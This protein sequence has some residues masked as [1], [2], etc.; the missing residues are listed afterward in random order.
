MNEERYHEILPAAYL[1]AALAKGGKPSALAVGLS[2]RDIEAAENPKNPAYRI[3]MAAAI[4]AVIVKVERVTVGLKS[5]GRT[6]EKFHIIFDTLTREPERQEINT[7]LLNDF[8]FG[9]IT[10]AVWDRWEPDGT[11]HWVGKRMTLYK[12]NDPPR[13]GDKSSAGFRCCVYA[14]PID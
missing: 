2:A 12:H 10:K 13:E 4:P 8:R 7:P 1:A 3:A 5:N 6:A 9:A 14:E 11:N